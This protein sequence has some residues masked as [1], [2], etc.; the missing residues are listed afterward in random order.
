MKKFLTIIFISLIFSFSTLIYSRFIG[1][2][3]LKTNETTITANIQKSFNGLKIVHF[4]DLHYKKII[5]EKRVKELIQEINKLKPDLVVFTG[6][7]IN[8]DYKLQNN[9][10]NFLI[11]ELKKIETTYGCYSIL[12]DNDKSDAET[13]KNI[14]LHSNFTL[15]NNSYD[16]IYNEKND[17]ILITD[18]ID[19]TIE[20]IN[21]P[22]IYKIVLTHTPDTID[23]LIAKN[24]AINI[25]LGGHSLNGSINIPYLKKLFLPIDAKKYYEPHYQ[26]NNTNIYINNGIGVDRINFRLFNHPSINFYRIKSNN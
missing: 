10:I 23:S 26:I 19:E 24:G 11:E 4:S 15:L 22:S 16:L 18:Y 13:I 17:K 25:I 2:I 20:T 3:F 6:D 14:Y 21:D 9:D 1:T 5:T 8:K 7:L 12:G